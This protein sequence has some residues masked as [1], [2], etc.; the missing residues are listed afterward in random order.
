MGLLLQL[1]S[2]TPAFIRA[3]PLVVVAVCTGIFCPPHFSEMLD[4]AAAILTHLNQWTLLPQ[5]RSCS[6]VSDSEEWKWPDEYA[7]QRPPAVPPNCQESSVAPSRHVKPPSNSIYDET[8]NIAVLTFSVVCVN[9]SPIVSKMCWEMWRRSRNGKEWGWG[10]SL[11]MN[12]RMW[13]FT[14]MLLWC[15]CGFRSAIRVGVVS[16]GKAPLLNFI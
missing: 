5:R 16:R 10:W 7:C 1:K 3:R 15:V 9:I 8:L 4:C 6:S 14:S 13:F 2:S 12:R 11:S